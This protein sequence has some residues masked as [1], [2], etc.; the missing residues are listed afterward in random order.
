MSLFKYSIGKPVYLI[1]ESKPVKKIVEK[2]IIELSPKKEN[3]SEEELSIF[4]HEP[5]VTITYKLHG[6]VP[7]FQE[8]VLFVSE[9]SLFEYILNNSR[10]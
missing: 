10:Q 2:V 8:N 3:Y 9:E 1:Y 4:G 5:K 6:L 7:L